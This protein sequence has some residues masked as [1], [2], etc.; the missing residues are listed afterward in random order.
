MALTCISGMRE[1][2]GCGACSAKSPVMV[3]Y[4]GDPIYSG[5][6]FYE[7]EGRIVHEN[8]ILDFIDEFRHVAD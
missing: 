7:I 1:C 8:N 6:E 2:D 5:D 4:S 3:D